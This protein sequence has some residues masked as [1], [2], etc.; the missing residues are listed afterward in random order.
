MSLVSSLI[1][2]IVGQ[3]SSIFLILGSYRPPH[4]IISQPSL[5]IEPYNYELM[6][7]VEVLLCCWINHLAQATEEHRE[8]KLEL[9]GMRVFGFLEMH[10]N[11]KD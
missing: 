4:P 1:H 3:L 5:S 8:Q 7:M 11:T 2:I 10:V 6:S 9:M